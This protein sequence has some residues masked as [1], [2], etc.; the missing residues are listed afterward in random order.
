MSNQAVNMYAINLDQIEALIRSV[1][2]KRTVLVQGHMGT[3]K[4]TLLRTL[5]AALPKHTPCYF[6]CTTKDLGDITLPRIAEAGADAAYVSYATNEELG[7]HHGGPIILMIDEYGKSN[8]SVKNALLRLMLERKIG[9]YSLHP[10]SIIFATTN[11]GAEGV[12]DLLP[13]HARNRITVVTA[14]KPSNM[15]W[16]EWGI[17][18]GIDHTLL[19]WCKDNPQLFNSFDDHKNPDDNP[20]IYH[21]KQQ[22]PSF[23][24]P[25]SLEAASDIL[26][27]RGGM[28]DMT[29]TAALMGTIGDRGAMDLMAFVKLADQLPSLESIKKSPDTAK[30]PTSAAA[31]CMVVYRTLASIDKEWLDA[32]MTYLVRL[33]KEA[34][35]MFANGVRAPK[36]SKQALIMTNRKFTDWAM[37]NSYL[38]AA[39]KR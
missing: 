28:D 7:A 13:P 21:P 26:K 27:S 25:R 4:S 18:S 16:I 6:D 36:Y 30:I 14:R 17:N 39:D 22:R 34:Q 38:F 37:Q 12:G 32:W 11:L 2:S 23:V 19:G 8:P 33:D 20:Y 31:V 5:S 35:G 10:D 3:G 9:S 29:V 24:T 15:E 1:G